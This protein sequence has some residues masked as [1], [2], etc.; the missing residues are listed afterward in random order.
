VVLGQPT[1]ADNVSASAIPDCEVWLNTAVHISGVPE[2]H[3]TLSE[4]RARGKTMSRRRLLDFY[5]H[6]DL[7]RHVDSFQ[8]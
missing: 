2:G 3:V 5:C 4:L 7:F 1:S 8:F 6:S